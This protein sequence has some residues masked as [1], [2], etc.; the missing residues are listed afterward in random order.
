MTTSKEAASVLSTVQTVAVIGAGISGISAAA[1][2]L[3]AGLS[4][5][6]FERSAASGGVWNYDPNPSLDTSYPNEKPSEGDYETS[7]P[8]QYAYRTP[9]PDT[10]YHRRRSQTTKDDDAVSISNEELAHAPPSACYA[11]LRNNIPLPLM[12]TS[13][14]SYPSNEPDLGRWTTILEYIRGIARDSGVDAVTVY[15]T[16][17]EEV[18]K[19]PVS[20]TIRTLTLDGA[21]GTNR[22]T[23]RG[24]VFDAVVVASGHYHTP[25]IPDMPRL[26]D[27]KADFPDRIIHSKQ[28][29]TPESFRGRNVLLVGG[30]VSSGDIARELDGV[31]NKIYQSVRGGKFDLSASLLP[32]SAERVASVEAF[33]PIAAGGTAGPDDHIPGHVQLLDGSVL[34]GIDN[35]VLA[36]GYL[37]S[38]PFLGHLHS[39]TAP[40]RSAGEEL[41]VT[42]DGAMTHNLHKDIF[43]MPDPSLAFLGVPFH[44][45]AFPTVDFQSQVI[46]R[47][48]SGQASLPTLAEMRDE[49]QRK[50]Q[51]KG[52]GRDFHCYL[53]KAGELE[54]VA[55]LVGWVNQEARARGSSLEVKGHSDEWV[56]KYWQLRQDAKSVFDNPSAWG[57]E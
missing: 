16:R 3:R 28:Y 49:Y 42:A 55:G 14:A 11:G 43:Y 47:V 8:G 5:T 21:E 50:V 51:Q 22:W 23:E 45:S 19:G 1:H 41:L 7:L 32:E 6:V 53:H 15:R 2:L 56:A 57:P 39:D 31:A 38:Y 44:L 24:W 20:W 9:P 18:K 46:A 25:R 29:R 36:T 13:L 30:G 48:F 35:I 54:Y 26:K 12:S 27:W 17:V 34:S 52:L 10:G 40:L 4:V 37:T 33:G